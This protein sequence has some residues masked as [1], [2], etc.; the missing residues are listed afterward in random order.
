MF[1]LRLADQHTETLKPLL[2]IDASC[3]FCHRSF[4]EHRALRQHLNFC[5]LTY[6]GDNEEKL[7]PE[8]TVVTVANLRAATF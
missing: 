3:L 5:R 4:T 7:A 6:E 8:P 2:G 1:F